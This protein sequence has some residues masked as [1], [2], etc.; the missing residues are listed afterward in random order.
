MVDQT[1]LCL[2]TL[3]RIFFGINWC[4]SMILFLSSLKDISFDFNIPLKSANLVSLTWWA[5][6]CGGFLAFDTFAFSYFALSVVSHVC[7]NST[8]LSI[9]GSAAPQCYF[10]FLLSPSTLLLDR[11]WLLSNW[12]HI[13]T[14]NW[15]P[16]LL[17]SVR[18]IN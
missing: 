8:A 18:K 3:Q 5:G 17:L 13:V 2:P 10:I 15:H 6:F 16:W 12:F 14:G 9:L 1:N 7:S 11:S 4:I